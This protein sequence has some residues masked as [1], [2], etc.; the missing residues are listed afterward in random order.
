MFV[1]FTVFGLPQP[2]GSIKAYMPKGADRPVLTSDNKNLKPWR[3]EVAWMAK[4]A[5]RKAGYSAWTR[6]TAIRVRVSFYFPTPKRAKVSYKT[7]KPDIDK[8]L[9][10]LLDALTGIC[11]EDDAQ[12]CEVTAEK[13]FSISPQTIVFVDVLS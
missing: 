4:E 11:Y 2:Q 6:P 9:R 3:Q 8:T 7:T 5:M 10:G 12:V 1:K 13:K